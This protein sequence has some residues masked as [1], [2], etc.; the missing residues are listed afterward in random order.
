VKTTTFRLPDNL[1]GEI[2]A[3]ARR[4][5][6]SRSDVVRERLETYAVR[7][8]PPRVAPSFRDLAADLIG[9]VGGDGLPPDLATRKKHYLKAWGYGQKRHRR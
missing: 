1:V 2:D 3:E 8:S 5:R 9:S 7:A 6:V 4:R